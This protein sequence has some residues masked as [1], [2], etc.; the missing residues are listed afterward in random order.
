MLHFS[1]DDTTWSKIG[2]FVGSLNAGSYGFAV[3]LARKQSDW[4]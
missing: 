1:N 2:E 3:D 4:L